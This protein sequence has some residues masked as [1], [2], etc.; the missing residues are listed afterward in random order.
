MVAMNAEHG[1]RDVQVFVLIVHPREPTL[2]H[3]FLMYKQ[4]WM[5][6]TKTKQNK[7]QKTDLVVLK[8]TAWSL[9]MLKVTG[10]SPMQYF[11]NIVML[12]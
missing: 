11:L 5:K 10:E 6:K 2:N 4:L 12:L 3:Y 7:E 8:L 9:R 1:N